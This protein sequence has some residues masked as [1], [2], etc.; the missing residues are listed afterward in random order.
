MDM[1]KARP[2]Q[3]SK[4]QSPKEILIIPDFHPDLG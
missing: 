4:D 2:I 3:R 1:A